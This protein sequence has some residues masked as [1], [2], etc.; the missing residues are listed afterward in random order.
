MNRRSS[1][2]LATLL[3]L[4]ACAATPDRFAAPEPVMQQRIG[5]L[6]QAIATLDESVDPEEA[7]RA[8]R[9][10]IEYS[11][12]LAQRY[13][14]NTS[15]LM[16]NLLV[17]LGV[18][19]RG[20]CV[21]WTEDLLA[22]LRAENFDSLDLHW[23]IANHDVAFSIEHS[24]VVISARGDSLYRGLVLD[25]WRDAGRLYWAYTLQDRDYPWQPQAQVHAYKRE[26]QDQLEPGQSDR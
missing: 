1:L 13:E 5:E 19:S 8:A 21:H 3:L 15:P 10:A 7:Q 16:H 9:I 20:L 22:R 25:P 24:T 2:L 18:R 26:L 23:A 14:V 11:L 6:R 4:T 17:N 12:E